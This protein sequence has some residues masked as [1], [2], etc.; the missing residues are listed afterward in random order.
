[1]HPKKQLFLEQLVNHLSQVPGIMA[2]V[3]GG[4]YASGT[5]RE[6]S[7]LDVGLYYHENE[8]FPIVEIKR[9]AESISVQGIPVVT[10]FYEWG[11]WVNGG[12][13]IQTDVGKVDFLY[14]NFDQVEWTIEDAYQG[15][16]QHDYDQQPTYGFYS[17]IYLA[18]THI[19]IPLHDPYSEIARLKQR[20]EI[21]PSKL[22]EKL[23]V[24]ALWSAEF[25]LGFAKS[26]AAAGDV[27]NTV[28]CLTRIAS[29]LT[30]ALFALNER[31]FISDKR[32]MD[33]IAAFS[34]L[35]SGYVNQITGILARPGGMV[36]EMSRTVINLEAVW[37]SVVS[38]AGEM[39]QPKFRT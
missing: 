23:V 35:P 11:P 22:K 1:M 32:V 15:I 2:I 37:Q 39:Y 24:E 12:A 18:E 16:V 30:Q 21:Y 31:Y 36:E 4:S 3:L 7:D 25:T 29:N 14:R 17:V 13:W 10:D 34:I 8:P 5:Y 28:G 19:C 33:T 20:V 26:F 38:L 6:N 27:Y 9:I